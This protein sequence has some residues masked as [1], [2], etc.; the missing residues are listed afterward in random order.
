MEMLLDEMITD[1][2]IQAELKLTKY[3]LLNES[4]LFPPVEENYKQ[5]RIEIQFLDNYPM[6]IYINLILLGIFIL[7]SNVEFYKYIVDNKM[8]RLFNIIENFKDKELVLENKLFN[9][10]KE[11]VFSEDIYNFTLTKLRSRLILANSRVSF[12]NYNNIRLVK[13]H[14]FEMTNGLLYKLKYFSEL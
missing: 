2:M 1:F 10:L 12:Y 14:N 11:L 13:G 3:I 6:H 4:F 8:L 5:G 7:L 9:K